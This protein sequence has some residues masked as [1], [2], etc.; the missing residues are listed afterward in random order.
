MTVKF[1]KYPIVRVIWEDSFTKRGWDQPENYEEAR[2]LFCIS[3]GFLFKRTRRLLTIVQ[4]CDE[5][6]KVGESINIPA[7]AVRKITTLSRG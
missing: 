4:S 7:C 1:P 5:Q 3:T 2:G 6:G